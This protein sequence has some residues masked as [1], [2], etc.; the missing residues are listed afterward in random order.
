[1]SATSERMRRGEKAP[2]H[3]RLYHW[4][5]DS[6][7][8]QSLD[9]NARAIYLEIG[10]RYAGAG[11]NNGRIPYSVREAATALKISRATASRALAA[12]EER[13]FVV[14][15]VKGAFSVKKRHA[16]EWRLTEHPCDITRALIGSK[17]FMRWEPPTPAEV[18][19][20]RNERRQTAGS[21]AALCG[22]ALASPPDNVH[23][24]QAGRRAPA[25]PLSPGK[26][27]V[28]L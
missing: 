16:T 10:R 13:G 11:S 22:G 18:E 21:R 1:M 27:V 20:R 19:R 4:L 7:A 5:M 23:P 8:W 28:S 6:R 12:L 3:V 9:A 14:P 26:L 2:R 17:E 24:L 15:T 25:K